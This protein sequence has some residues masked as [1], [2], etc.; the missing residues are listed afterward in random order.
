MWNQLRSSAES[1]GSISIVSVDYDSS[2]ED[3]CSPEKR[4]L[5]AVLEQAIR[6]CLEK[7]VAYA[8]QAQWWIFEDKDGDFHWPFSFTWVC[9]YLDI[10][11]EE[12]Q[13]RVR[14][15]LDHGVPQEIQWNFKRGAG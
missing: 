9:R 5:L 2:S 1:P 10:D 13:S 8:K 6:D 3:K 15:F 7:D 14:Y 4:L 11:P 12:V